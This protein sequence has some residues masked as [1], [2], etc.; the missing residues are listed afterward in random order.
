MEKKMSQHMTRDINMYIKNLEV[1]TEE[2]RREL[3]EKRK[4]VKKK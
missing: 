3:N 2:V 1:L 4:K